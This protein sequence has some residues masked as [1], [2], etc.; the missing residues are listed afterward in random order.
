MI[1][2]HQQAHVS[3]DPANNSTSSG[4]FALNLSSREDQ[5]TTN[6][7]FGHDLAP[8]GNKAASSAATTRTG[9]PSGVPPSLLHDVVSSFSS[10]SGFEG[11]SFE[12]AFGGIL[13]AKT[14]KDANFNDTLPK[15]TTTARLGSAADDGGGGNEG[16]TRDFLGLRPLSHSDILSIAGIGNC[17]TTSTSHD[18]QNQSEKPW[19]G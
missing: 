6:A 15:T 5:M 18:Q 19:Q 12:D 11:T 14:T 4:N 13:N 7:G 10:A 9:A 1:R 2:T 17:M 16:L 3:A 8:F